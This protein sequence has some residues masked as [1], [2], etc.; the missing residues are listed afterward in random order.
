ML[1]KNRRAFWIWLVMILIMI[2]M[3]FKASATPYAK[4]DMQPF[5]QAHFQWTSETFPHVAFV[6]DGQFVTSRNP[7]EFFE[8]VIRKF[9]HVVEFT[10]LTFVFINF[11]MTTVMPRLLCYVCGPCL[12]MIYALFDEWH[13]TFVPGRTGHFIDAFSFDLAGMI[14]GTFIVFL[15]DLYVQFLYTGSRRQQSAAKHVESSG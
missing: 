14:I 11:L 15:L 8:F 1:L 12:S 13:Q 2:G 3:I 5:L 10:G 4:Q 7:Y 6:Y 9:C